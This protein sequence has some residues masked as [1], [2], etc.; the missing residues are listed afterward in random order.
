MARSFRN[1]CEDCEWAASTENHSQG[2]L[3]QLA[4]DHTV[5]HGHDIESEVSDNRLP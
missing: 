5:D 4:I 3:S 2:A 1:Y